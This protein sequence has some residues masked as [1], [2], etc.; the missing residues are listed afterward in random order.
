MQSRVDK[1]GLVW[2]T[3]DL[4]WRRGY[5]MYVRNPISGEVRNLAQSQCLELIR[6]GWVWAKAAEYRKW[7]VQR[8]LVLMPMASTKQH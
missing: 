3:V 7:I 8:A 6:Y 2:Y 1:C 5:A 4:N